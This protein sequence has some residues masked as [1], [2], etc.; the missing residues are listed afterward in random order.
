MIDILHFHRI[1]GIKL[2]KVLKQSELLSLQ[3]KNRIINKKGI[4]IKATHSLH[5]K[6]GEYE[7]QKLKTDA[8]ERVMMLPT[9]LLKNLLKGDFTN[10]YFKLKMLFLMS[11]EIIIIF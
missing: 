7:L 11:N 5:K 10:F 2:I 3:A 6:K 8:G 9:F 1:L 4:Y